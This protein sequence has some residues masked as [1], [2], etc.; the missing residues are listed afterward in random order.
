[1]VRLFK[2]AVLAAALLPVGWAATPPATVRWG[3]T[4]AGDPIYLYTLVNGKG[5]E[6]RVTNFG[7]ILVSLKTP[8]RH[9][10]PAD[11]VLGFD[12]FE[13]YLNTRRYYGATIGRYAN[14]IAHA[15][16]TLDGQQYTL[17]R[18]NG[19]HSLH[20]GNRGFHKVVWEGRVVVGP[21]SAVEFTYLSRDGEEG[22]PGNLTATVRYTLTA[23][24]LHIDYSA[25][26]D[27]P[28]VVNLTNHSYWNLSG[29]G[30]GDV[31]RQ[32]VTIAAD[33]FT[34]ADAGLIPTGELRTVAGTPFDFRKPTPIGAQID[35][36]DEQLRGPRGYDHNYVLN[37]APGKLAF[38][39]RVVDPQSGRIMEIRTTE[40]GI[41]FYTANTMGGS[42]RGKGGHVYAA[43]TAL[44]LEPGHFPDSP[45]HLEFPSTSLRPGARYRSTTIYRF[46][47]R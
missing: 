16:F 27:K 42:E 43:R 10:T 35:A 47:A 13:A 34:P 19:Q 2:F 36:D 18:N 3:Q 39:A 4:P 33:R 11:V 22:F 24:E 38:A 7:A 17:A 14:R 32:I 41:Q 25:T 40:P 31:L 5:M 1:M 21:P 29:E 44:C 6:A 15:S 20:G 28:T 23:S 12:T 30:A 26:T 8:D 46:T 37:H 45:N 9:G